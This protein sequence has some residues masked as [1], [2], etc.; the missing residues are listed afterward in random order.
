MAAAP[1]LILAI[2]Q[3]TSSTKGL[4]VDRA[5]AVVAQGTAPL[6]ETCPQPG[7]VEQDPDAI[8]DSVAAAVASTLRGIDPARV[9]AVGFSTQRES[10]LLWDKRTGQAISPLLSW[11]DQ[12]TT[13]IA[14]ALGTPTVRDTVRRLSGLPLDPMFSALKGR[15]LLDR[16]DPD[17]TRSRAGEIALGTVDSWLLFRLGGEHVIEIGNASRTQ[18]LD[19]AQARWS[20][21]LCDLFGIPLQAL[22][23]ILPSTGPFPAIRNLSPLRDGTP[24]TAVLGDSHAALF[25]QGGFRAGTVKATFGTGSSV[26]GLLGPDARDLDEGTCLT[27]GWQID[28][29]APACAAEGNIRSAGSTLRW[30]AEVLGLSV[31]ALV[32]EGL[33]ASRGSGVALVPAFNGLGA[34]YWDDEACATLCGFKLG[35]SRAA[36][37]R[38]AVESIPH[39]VADVI[40]SV[41]RSTGV[42]VTVLYADGGP[43]AND[44]LMQLQAD[45]AGLTV[46]RSPVAGLSAIGAA[47]MAGLGAGFWNMAGLAAIER[48]HATFAAT[49]PDGERDG[50]RRDWVRA[51]ARARYRMADAFPDETT[52]A[53]PT[54]PPMRLRAAG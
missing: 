42:P 15:W 5:G 7:W 50:E 28:G 33:S 40:A 8:W 34:P 38:A 48:P 23:R 14:R 3:G 51:V 1:D 13:G 26:M 45:L 35:T 54:S 21:E 22:P 25:G 36:L 27:I 9:A 17:R 29:E 4:L 53:T 49:M 18:L 30:L 32:G 16:H 24:V 41:E 43:S 39:Q 44:A 47:H 52:A 11:Q 46:L 2:D 10:L 37:A 12:R 19:T 6:G 20:D 31:E